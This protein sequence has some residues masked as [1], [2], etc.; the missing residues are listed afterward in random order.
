MDTDRK[1]RG[2]GTD[3]RLHTGRGHAWHKGANKNQFHIFESII[4][5]VPVR[6]PQYLQGGWAISRAIDRQERP[7]AIVRGYATA[8][9]RR[10]LA[11]SAS[12]RGPWYGLYRGHE[13]EVG[14]DLRAWGSCH[15]CL[16]PK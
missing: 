5:K 8:S 6:R 11:A 14:R 10:E 3:R 9:S 4:A 1:N 12:Q 16:E 13:I 15:D 7:C 2:L